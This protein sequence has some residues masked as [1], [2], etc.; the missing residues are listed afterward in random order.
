M[1]VPPN[2]DPDLIAAL[3]PR[4]RIEG[5]AARVRVSPQGPP[6]WEA[7]ALVRGLGVDR[8]QRVPGFAGLDARLRADQDDGEVPLGSTGLDLDP[9]PLFGQ[10]LHLDHL[11]GILTWGRRPAGGWR[12][13]GRNLEL[14]NA[15]L[16]GRVRFTLDLPGPAAASRDRPLP[17]PAGEPPRWRR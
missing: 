8:Y 16:A 2:L 5:L 14:E 10:P 4:A 15:D 1:P 6:T 7:A 3:N 11:T 9:R 17:G 12:L 13:E